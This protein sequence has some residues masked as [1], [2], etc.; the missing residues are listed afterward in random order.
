MRWLSSFAL[1]LAADAAYDCIKG[2]VRFGRV[3][4]LPRMLL[5]LGGLFLMVGEWLLKKGLL[6]VKSL[7]VTPLLT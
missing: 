5:W 4:V 3:T 2:A 1:S 6:N 7:A